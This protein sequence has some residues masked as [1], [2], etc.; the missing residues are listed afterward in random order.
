MVHTTI[1]ENPTK[2]T[3][4]TPIQTTHHQSLHKFH[5]QLKR[6]FQ[7]CHYSK[8]FFSSQ[9]FTMK[10]G[11][12]T[13]D[14]KLSYNINNQKKTIKTKGKKNITLF[15]SS[16][17]YSKFVKTIIGRILIK[18]ISKHFP[19]NHKFAKI[20]NKNNKTQLFSHVECQIK[21]KIQKRAK[22]KIQKQD[23]KQQSPQS[24]KKDAI[25]LLK[26]IFQ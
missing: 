23:K 6:G 1:T 2:P 7:L 11:I 4:F 5:D 19:P 21:I 3:K 13:V 17:R 10:K 20:F 8:I 15:D 26:K 22:T 12:K 9:P 25:V 18:L 16:H 14:I 24:H